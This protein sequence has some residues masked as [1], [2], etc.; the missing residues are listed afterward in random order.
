MTFGI[1]FNPLCNG[2]AESLDSSRTLRSGA[3]FTE[4]ANRLRVAIGHYVL[5]VEHVGSTAKQAF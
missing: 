1:G 4:E 5:A 3:L 2:L